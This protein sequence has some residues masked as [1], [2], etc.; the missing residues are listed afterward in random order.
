MV[1]IIAVVVAGGAQHGIDQVGGGGLAVGAGDAGERDPLVR[2][3]VEI[4]RGERQRLPAV[5]HLDPAARE[6]PG[7]A[8]DS[9]DH[10]H[11][12]ARQRVGGELRGRRPW[13]PGKAKN[14]N[15]GPTRRES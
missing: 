7:G 9:L 15:P 4:A 1:P 6:T 13:L 3:A 5:L 2:P 12:A 14:R 11:R 10:R 8:G